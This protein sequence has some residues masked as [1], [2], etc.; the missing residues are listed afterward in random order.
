[1]HFQAS[2]PTQYF[3]YRETL[4]VS[5]DIESPDNF[6]FVIAGCLLVAWILVY[7]CIVKGITE[8]PKI[9]YVTA[10]YPYIVLIIFFFRAV[11]L[12]GMSDGVIHLFSP[13]VRSSN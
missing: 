8:N 10:I 4:N 13:K 9:I 11:T 12:E 7:I 2:S 6:N 3:W 5:T 1:L